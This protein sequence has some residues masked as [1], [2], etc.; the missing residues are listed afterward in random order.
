[1]SS[2][3]NIFLNVFMNIFVLILKCIELSPRAVAAAIK[4]AHDQYALKAGWR[5]SEGPLIH[6][7]SAIFVKENTFHWWRV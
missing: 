2:F 6:A 3:L 5:K 7:D 4:V 1:M